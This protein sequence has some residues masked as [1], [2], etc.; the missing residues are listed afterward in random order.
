MR[1]VNP[2]LVLEVVN[3]VLDHVNVMDEKLVHDKVVEVALFTG[4]RA[5][6]ACYIATAKHVNAVFVTNDRVMR[7][8]ALKSGVKAR[9][10]LDDRN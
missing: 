6:D 5:V 8:N 1:R 3:M 2:R 7:D 9:Y 4:C 10:L